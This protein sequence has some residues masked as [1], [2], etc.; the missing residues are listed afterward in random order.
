MQPAP[1]ISELRRA[2]SRKLLDYMIPQSFVIL[3][4]LP[5]LP[6]G[7]VNRQALPKPTTVRPHLEGPF[8]A[9]RSPVEE[10]LA[11]IW[12][13]VLDLDEIGIDD[14]FLELGGDSLRAGQVISRVISTFRVELSLSILFEA[15]T[16]ADMAVAIVQNLAKDADAQDIE[17]MLAELEA[18]C[19]EGEHQLLNGESEVS[20]K[21]GR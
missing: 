19:E 10:R 9:P 16:V 18:R 5:L 15:A 6:N 17:R 12:A 1:N 3:D 11:N 7:K 21:S 4:Q 8:I 2:L 14:N 20:N 13:E